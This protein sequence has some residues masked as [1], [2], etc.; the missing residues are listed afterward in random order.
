MWLKPLYVLH[1][2][3]AEQRLPV[4]PARLAAVIRP[5]QRVIS[6][7]RQIHEHVLEQPPRR[8]LP[9]FVRQRVARLRPLHDFL[10]W[11]VLDENPSPIRPPSRY[12]GGTPLAVAAVGFADP[13]VERGLQLIGRRS[14]GGVPLRPEAPQERA[15]PF[16]RQRAV[17]PRL[18][19]R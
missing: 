5:D 4:R 9:D 17:D 10:R 1:T 15:L 18:V 6:K 13:A 16:D 19:R 8:I 14:R 12:L 7:L 3:R 2:F 11:P